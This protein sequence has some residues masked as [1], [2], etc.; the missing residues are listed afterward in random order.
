MT[1]PLGSLWPSSTPSSLWPA[2]TTPQ[3]TR[4][5]TKRNFRKRQKLGPKRKVFIIVID[6]SEYFLS[7]FIL[8]TMF[9]NK[10][11]KFEIDPP[12]W[13]QVVKRNNFWPVIYFFSLRGEGSTILQNSYL[14]AKLY[15]NG[16]PPAVSEIFCYKHSNR[17]CVTFT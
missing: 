4:S 3:Y 7:Y 12:L 14:P 1:T 15:C 2:V 9:F 5:T 8:L 16:K 10:I 13:N 6:I 17:H 11:L